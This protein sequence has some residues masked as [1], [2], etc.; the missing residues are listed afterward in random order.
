MSVQRKC[1]DNQASQCQ[2]NDTAN[3]TRLI[4]E[5]LYN[6]FALTAR[7]DNVPLHP[8]CCYALPWAMCFCAYS[9]C[10]SMYFLRAS[11]QSKSGTGSIFGYEGTFYAKLCVGD[12]KALHWRL[13]SFALA[14]AKL[15][16][17]CCKALRWRMQCFASE[18]GN[19]CT[20][21]DSPILDK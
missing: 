5:S 20:I 9:A 16:V 17:G 18:M 8:G 6:A 2:K 14:I 13:Q 4:K 10:W 7:I 3:I 12:Y 15:C 19:P 1:G 11:S 21:I